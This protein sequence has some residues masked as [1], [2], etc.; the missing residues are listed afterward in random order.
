MKNAVMGVDYA[1][2]KDNE[3]YLRGVHCNNCDKQMRHVYESNRKSVFQCPSCKVK[4]E[5]QK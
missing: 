5:V 1:V 4:A 3:L 2:Q